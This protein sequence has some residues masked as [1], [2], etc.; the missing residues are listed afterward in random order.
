MVTL[1]DLPGLASIR[2]LLQK[3]YVDGQ[4]VLVY[5]AEG[6]GQ[7]DV[8]STLAQ[9]WLC[10]QPSENGGC[11]DCKA[12]GAFARGMNADFQLIKP[13]GRSNLLKTAAIR[14]ANDPEFGGISVQDFSRTLPLMSSNKVVLLH[15]VDRMTS[16]AANSFLKMLEEPGPQMRYILTSRAIG[17]VLPTIISRCLTLPCEKPNK[18]TGL[19]FEDEV[20][21]EV[22]QY[23]R[24]AE[25]PEVLRRLVEI[26]DELGKAPRHAALQF[27]ERLRDIADDLPIGEDAARTKQAAAL[28][29]FAVMVR[30]RYPDRGDWLSETIEAHRRIV[31]NAVGGMVTDV[32]FA[33]MLG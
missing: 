22:A 30:L 3:L 25:K 28:E 17:R 16:E 14:P 31:G 4:S 33:R 18:P 21:Y 32:M 5:G 6:A 29:I 10:L 11:G 27:S 2:P 19:S 7:D 1:D 9:A 13:W 12:C 24:L 23:R 20:L 15:D 26:V 8:A